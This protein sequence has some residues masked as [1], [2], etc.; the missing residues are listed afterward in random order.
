MDQRS[1][2]SLRA[3]A[4]VSAGVV[5][6][7]L[8]TPAGAAQ[9][10]PTTFTNSRPTVSGPAGFD[11]SRALRPLA[12]PRAAAGTQALDADDE[13]EEELQARLPAA[14]AHRLSGYAAV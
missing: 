11:T 5:V 8:L 10:E 6:A 2:R 3:T 7:A 14:A 1:P 4:L 13:R 9:A 12:P